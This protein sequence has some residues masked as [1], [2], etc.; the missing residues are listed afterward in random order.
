MRCRCTRF[1]FFQFFVFRRRCYRFEFVFEP[2]RVV[3]FVTMRSESI[4]DSS[5]LIL[6][7]VPTC[8]QI[9][10]S[11][12]EQYLWYWRII[13]LLSIV[14]FVVTRAEQKYSCHHVPTAFTKSG[15]RACV[16]GV[17]RPAQTTKR[18]IL[19]SQL[20]AARTGWVTW[21]A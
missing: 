3:V 14:V 7:H 13:I 15:T 5:Q 9:V 20:T 21:W 2:S 12:H 16:C 10:T 11:R 19:C 1:F 17:S 4:S 18:Q 6:S 8:T